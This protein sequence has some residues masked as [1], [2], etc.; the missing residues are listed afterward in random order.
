GS[1]D[2]G[3]VRGVVMLVM[4][5]AVS[6]CA[7]AG[8]V[9]DEGGVFVAVV[10][11]HL[12]SSGV[13]PNSEATLEDLKTKHPFH[14]APSLPHIPIDHHH[15]IASSTVVLDKIKSFPCG[16]SCGQDGLRAQHLMDCLSGVVVVVSGELVSSI[17]QVVNLFLAGNY[18]LM[19]GKYI[20]NAPLTSL[21]KP[22]GGIR[23]IAM[24]TFWR[25]LVSKLGVGVS[26][27]SEAIL[28]SVNRLIES[29]GDDIGLSTLLVDFKNAFNLVVRE[30]MLCEVHPCFPAISRWI[31]DIF[32]ISLH[33]WYLEDGTIVG[34]TL[35]VGKVLELIM[36]DGPGC[37]L[38]L[39]VDKTK[40]FLAKER[41][42][43]QACSC[44]FF[45]LVR[46]FPGY[47]L[48]CAHVLPMSLSLPN[49]LLTWLFVLLWSIVTASGPGFGDWQWR[50]STLPFAFGGIGVYSAGDVLNYAF[51]AS[52]LQSV[53]LQNK[54]LRHTGI[55]ASGPLFEDALSVFNT[56]MET[57]LLSNPSEI[58]APKLMK[59]MTDK[60][61]F[62]LT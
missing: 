37:G 55:V 53:G 8:V 29:C 51:L 32:S 30:V 22:G 35:V 24:G 49:I 4:V 41:P 54:L 2:G 52:R 23:P 5:A 1:D 9:D 34:D 40:V 17:T 60:C 48:L 31:R 58:T 10:L 28:Q 26:E 12:S 43:K 36:E 16:T 15:L 25:R 38:H 6:R 57:D 56:S 27:G 45:V 61:G 3:V 44:C 14:P 47:T 19:L 18:P 39:N 11:L 33:A 62:D 21:V 42:S 20:A 7:S 50:L 46:V 59:K 13:T